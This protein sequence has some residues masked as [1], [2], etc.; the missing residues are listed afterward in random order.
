MDLLLSKFNISKTVWKFNNS[1]LSNQDYLHLINKV[2][3]E[4]MMKYA[5]PIYSM[6][7]LKDYNNYGMKI[8]VLHTLPLRLILK[9]LMVSDKCVNFG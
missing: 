7:F 9:S 1:L 3:E 6:Q 2:I 5:V 8:I 4:E